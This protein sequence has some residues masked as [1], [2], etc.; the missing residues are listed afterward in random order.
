MILRFSL[1]A[2]CFPYLSACFGY[3]WKQKAHFTRSRATAF[4]VDI[5]ILAGWCS[6]KASGCPDCEWASLRSPTHC[7]KAGL[8]QA[9]PLHQPLSFHILSLERPLVCFILCPVSELVLFMLLP[10]NHQQSTP[11]PAPLA[12]TQWGRCAQSPGAEF[13]DQAHT[14]CKHLL[15]EPSEDLKS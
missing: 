14:Q 3:C 1:C 13:G 11:S 15:R 5:V 4:P 2:V 7:S 12:K 8:F 10:T 6:G 9:H